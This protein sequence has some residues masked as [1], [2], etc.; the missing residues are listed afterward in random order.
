MRKFYFQ[1]LDK[2]WLLEGYRI[3]GSNASMKGFYYEKYC[4]ALIIF[5]NGEDHG[6]DNIKLHNF[7][8]NY[9]GVSDVN[10]ELGMHFY[11]PE[12]FNLRYVDLIVRWLTPEFT[13]IQF[14]QITLQS[15]LD[16]T[17]SFNVFTVAHNEDSRNVADYKRYIRD[18]DNKQQMTVEFHWVTL[19]NHV[20]KPP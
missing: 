19:P 14:L 1:S 17:N 12:K 3:A 18:D 6:W 11:I 20:E 4:I 2:N 10:K 13:L 8:G 15:P 9:P 5:R 16:H 7:T